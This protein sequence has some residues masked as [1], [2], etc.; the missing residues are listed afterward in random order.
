ML[1]A[2]AVAKH[3]CCPYKY[4]PIA[5]LKAPGRLN[6]NQLA[7]LDSRDRSRLW[8]FELIER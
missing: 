6:R 4:P 7:A 8:R 3:H 5:D 2:K 1:K